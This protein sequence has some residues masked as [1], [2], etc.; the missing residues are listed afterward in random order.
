MVLLWLTVW[1]GEPGPLLWASSLLSSRQQRKCEMLTLGQ[2]G[3]Q[4]CR[5]ELLC[6]SWLE[7]GV[8]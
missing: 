4:S 7:G 1:P 8:S 2:L 5:L 6:V 3:K